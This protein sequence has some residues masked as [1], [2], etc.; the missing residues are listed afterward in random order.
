MGSRAATAPLSDARS[1]ASSASHPGGA[2]QT[3]RLNLSR[4]LAKKPLPIPGVGRGAG[5]V[6]RRYENH[7]VRVELARDRGKILQR[8]LGYLAFSKPLLANLPRRQESKLE[9]PR[10]LTPPATERPR[11]LLRKERLL[12]LDE[13]EFLEVPRRSDRKAGAPNRDHRRDLSLA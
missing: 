8:H 2:S 3:T 11:P 10:R 13:R 9:A 5:K 12:N 6:R 4:T 1:W 7:R